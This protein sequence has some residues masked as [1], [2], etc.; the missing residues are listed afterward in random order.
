MR[1]ARCVALLT[2]LFLLAPR[3]DAQTF[4]VKAPKGEVIDLGYAVNP[5][6]ADLLVILEIDG[7]IH[8]TALKPK[9][10]GY[11]GKKAKPISGSPEAHR[12]YA[13]YNQAA[14]EYLV[15]WDTAPADLAALARLRPPV[16]AAGSQ[17]RIQRVRRTNGRK[18]G[19]VVLHG[20]PNTLNVSP[21]FYSWGDP[22]AGNAGLMWG[23]S[24]TP[25]VRDGARQGELT[26]QEVQDIGAF[27]SGA[28]PREILTGLSFPA[29]LRSVNRFTESGELAVGVDV[30]QSTTLGNGLLV[31]L[32]PESVLY[33]LRLGR[34]ARVLDAAWH[35]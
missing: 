1:L 21:H 16:R 32:E 22:E 24:D 5:E 14:G 6:T 4:R 2:L 25:A 35:L 12:A 31:G 27:L 15:A 20:D 17:I 18:V 8:A 9:G 10:G 7:R 3:A 34:V 23:A 13:M 28:L 26:L 11:K 30:F 29:E 33:L 19:D